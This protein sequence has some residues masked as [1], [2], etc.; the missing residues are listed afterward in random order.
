M[1]W[2]SEVAEPP[3]HLEPANPCPG[4]TS[5]LH[6]DPSTLP[7][8]FAVSCHD[9]IAPRRHFQPPMTISLTPDHQRP[10]TDISVAS[11]A[12]DGVRRMHATMHDRLLFSHFPPSLNSF[13]DLERR[14]HGTVTEPSISPETWVA[15]LARQV[16]GSEIW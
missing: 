7:T 14:V 1:A 5:H 4:C 10:E 13:L 12:Q 8:P 16:S 3:K 2:V 9:R 15:V 11:L 6:P